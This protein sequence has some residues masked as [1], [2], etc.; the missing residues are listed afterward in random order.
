MKSYNCLLNLRNGI[1][2]RVNGK[3]LNYISLHERDDDPSITHKNSLNKYYLIIILNVTSL[4]VSLET[5]T[6]ITTELVNPKSPQL[7]FVI[8][9]LIGLLVSVFIG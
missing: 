3:S 8:D 4:L 9:R 1:K 7:F 6:I 2:D 5:F